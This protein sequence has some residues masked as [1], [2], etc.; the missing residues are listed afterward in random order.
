MWLAEILRT[1]TTLADQFDPRGIRRAG[2]LLYSRIVLSRDLTR[3]FGLEQGRH[4]NDTRRL[5]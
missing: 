4:K 3:N 1:A 5:N 2:L